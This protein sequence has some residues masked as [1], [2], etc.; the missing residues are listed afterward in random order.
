MPCSASSIATLRALERRGDREGARGRGERVAADVDQAMRAHVESLP[1]WAL[2]PGSDSRRASSRRRRTRVTRCAHAHGRGVV[3]VGEIE[4]ALSEALAVLEADSTHAAARLL[5]GHAL[6]IEGDFAGAV[7][8]LAPLLDARP[9]SYLVVR[10]LGI[11]YAELGRTPPPP[12]TWRRRS[13][14]TRPILNLTAARS[15]SRGGGEIRGGAKF[16]PVGPRSRMR[17]TTI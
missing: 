11:A 12:P 5:L 7:T 10:D 15:H 13:G 17:P 6:L 4:T 14:P 1:V 16:W 3:P 9:V 2:G 8:H